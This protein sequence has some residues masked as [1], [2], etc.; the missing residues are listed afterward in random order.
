[1]NRRTFLVTSTASAFIASMPLTGCSTATV[2][3]FVKLI[4]TDAE[5]LASFFGAS[6]IAS[7]ISTLA[8]QITT[9]ITNWQNGGTA[10]DAIQAINDLIGVVNLIPIAIPYAPLLIL[11]LSALSGLLALLPSATPTP[12]SERAL[13]ER[14]VTPMHIG[15]TDKTHI[16]AA[17]DQFISQWSSQI[18]ITPLTH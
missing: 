3:T 5:A 12:A 15:G 13:S 17:S 16:K 6:S 11:I 4:V 18:A 10:A 1:M 7:Q 14:R 9:D 8:G 2:A